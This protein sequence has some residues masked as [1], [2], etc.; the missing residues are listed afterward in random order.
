MYW[1]VVY[2]CMMIVEITLELNIY[3]NIFN[4]RVV[5]LVL[6]NIQIYFLPKLNSIKTRTVYDHKT[7]CS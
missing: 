5:G 4:E 3:H 1:L 2:G 7:D 6:S